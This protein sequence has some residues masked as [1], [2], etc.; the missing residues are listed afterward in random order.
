MA[1]PSVSVVIP[2]HRRPSERERAVRAVLSQDYDA[3][4][5]CIVVFDREDP[6]PIAAPIS[7]AR[8]LRLIRNDRTPGPAGARNAG[9]LVAR[10]DLLGFCDDD[11]E[12]LPQKLHL[13]ATALLHH[14]WAAVAVSGVT[15]R[16]GGRLFD[17]VSPRNRV[18]LADL[19]R[20]RR[21]DIEPSGIVV[22]K[23]AFLNRI[24]LFDEGTPGGYA[25]DYDWLLRAARMSPLVAVQ[26]PLV[27]MD[28]DGSWFTRRWDLIVS[29]S[30]YLLEKHPE[31]R[32]DR[33]NLGRIYGRIAFAC[34]A[35][36][37]KQVARQ[38]A[39]RAVAV[40]WREPR[41]YLAVLVAAGLLRP[42]TVV[43]VAA[44]MGRGL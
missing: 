40:D 5:E 37:R 18:E 34:A 26:R 13:Q 21:A 14:P 29:A 10:G 6:A 38:W 39:R 33:R 1:A 8:E 4:I 2:T 41:S 22:W 7:P 20:S 24:G 27:V 16:S 42:E 11:D 23:D 36:G 3:P 19:I 25:E 15:Y 30:E 31:L 35:L 9:A 43:R 28:R 32:T 17:R 12:W 44:S